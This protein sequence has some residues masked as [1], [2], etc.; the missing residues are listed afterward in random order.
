MEIPKT[1]FGSNII[2]RK[3]KKGIRTLNLYLGKV[4]LYQLSYFRVS[5]Y[6]LNGKLIQFN[7]KENSFEDLQFECKDTSIL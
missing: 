2:Y 6:F 5:F 1:A 3:A 7:K 4:I